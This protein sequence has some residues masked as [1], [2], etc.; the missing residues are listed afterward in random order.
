MRVIGGSA[1][2]R[3]LKAKLP[4]TV[5]PTTDFAREAIFSMLESRGGLE[6]LVVADLY[7][8]SG[9]MGIEALSRGASKV[10]F[11]DADPACLAAVRENLE[12]FHLA[13]EAIYVRATLPLW[14]P[15]GDLD[16][17]LADPPYGPLDVASVL[18][19]VRAERVVV[20]N[21]HHVEAPEGWWVTKTKRYGTTLVTMLEPAPAEDA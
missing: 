4:A 2:G 17:V 8:G 5:R 12:P 1:R 18:R 14:S 16:L 11:V 9:A 19:G 10:Y 3:P 6:D 15:P 7:C 21:D 20:E 13:G